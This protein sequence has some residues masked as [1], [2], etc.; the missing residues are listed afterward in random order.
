MPENEKKHF[1]IDRVC[2]PDEESFVIFA[3]VFRS[4]SFQRTI[5]AD[6]SDFGNS[7]DMTS[8]CTWEIRLFD[9]YDPPIDG[10][11]LSIVTVSR[12]SKRLIRAHLDRILLEQSHTSVRQLFQ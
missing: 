6:I 5:L 4:F 8:L 10:E 12:R 2:V 11:N 1:P 7:F 9:G 3:R